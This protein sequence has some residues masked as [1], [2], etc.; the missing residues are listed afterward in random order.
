[1]AENTKGRQ[2]SAGLPTSEPFLKK[3]PNPLGAT[4]MTWTG[5]PSSVTVRPT[6]PASP[7]KRRFHVPWLSTT[8]ASRPSGP[9][10]GANAR[11]RTGATPS[12]EK[13][14]GFTN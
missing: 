7:P 11:P 2:M 3:K 10:S 14:F 13:K 5:S 12:V 4:P 8:T 6:I 9:S 1:L